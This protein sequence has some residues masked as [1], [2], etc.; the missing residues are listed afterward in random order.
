M[1]AVPIPDQVIDEDSG[2][3]NVPLAGVFTDID[4][5]YEGEAWDDVTVA[6][7]G[8]GGGGPGPGLIDTLE[9]VGN[10][11]VA[12][13]NEHAFGV[14]DI[15]VTVVDNIAQGDLRRDDV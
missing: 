3:L 9:I 6:A 4:F 2:D 11:V 15:T 7:A 13:F 14:V 12:T 8:G 10:S 1:V 5:T